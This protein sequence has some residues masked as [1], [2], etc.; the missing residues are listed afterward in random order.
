[1]LDRIVNAPSG[2]V[3]FDKLQTDFKKH[4]QRVKSIQ[5]LQK[6]NSTHIIRRQPEFYNRTIKFDGLNI[7][8]PMGNK[9]F[10]MTGIHPMSGTGISLGT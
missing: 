8:M 5:K 6:M 10:E 3:P 2:I 1:M 9:A 4:K 7:M